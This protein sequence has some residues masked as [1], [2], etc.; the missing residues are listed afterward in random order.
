AAAF[1]GIPPARYKTPAEQVQF[2]DSVIE[3]LKAHGQVKEAAAV[4]GLPLGGFNPRSP[5]SVAGRPVLPLPQRPLA[6]LAIVTEEYFALMRIT[7]AA[8]RVF[9]ADD[10]EGA[11][12]VCIVNESLGKRLFPGETALGKVLLRGRDAE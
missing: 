3:R 11:P 6:G 10:R 1:V 9:T 5:Y 2:F 12:G 7:L 4:I 8:G